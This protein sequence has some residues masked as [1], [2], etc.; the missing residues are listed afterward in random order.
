MDW[1]LFDYKTD[2]VII[3]GSLKDILD[4]WELKYKNNKNITFSPLFDPNI[5]Y[6]F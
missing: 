6:Y 1:C 3:E 4:L 5:A 2:E